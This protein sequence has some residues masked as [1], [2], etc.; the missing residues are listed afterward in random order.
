MITPLR[1]AAAV[2]PSDDNS[3]QA[4]LGALLVS[5]AAYFRVADFLRAEHF[6][7]AI[8]GRIYA[9]I[10]QTI[11]TGNPAV[12]I[13]LG[14]LFDTEEELRPRGGGLQYLLELARNAVTIVNVEFYGRR[15]VE[16][17]QRR[18]LF[19]AAQELVEQTNQ[20]DDLETTARD[21]YA[22]F[23][24][25]AGKAFDGAPDGLPII[26]VG[27]DREPIP[28]RE[29][30]LG[31][32]FCRRFVS[33]LV[34]QGSTG[35]T[36]LRVAQAIAVATGRE[37]TG[38]HV[39]VRCRVLIVS[40]EDNMDELRRRVR[41]AVLHH[42][43]ST[44]ELRGWLFLWTPLGL[45]IADQEDH[46]RKVVPGELN[47]RLRKHIADKK[48]DLVMIDP[49]VKAHQAD[50]ND[51]NAMDQVAIILGQLAVDFNCAIDTPIHERKGGSH[52]IGDGDRGRGASSYR[53]ASRLLYTGTLM[54]EDEREKFGL[55]ENERRS[56]FR[57]D[58]AKV[59]IAPPSLE[60][61][62][63][64]I[65]GV[66]IGNASAVYPAG[67][68]VPTVEPWE[69]PDVWSELSVAIVNA[70]L[71]EIERGPGD[72]RRYSSAGAVGDDRAAWHVVNRHAPELTEKQC[73]RVIA[74]WLGSGM[75]I[76][77]SYQDPAQRRPRQ[78]LFVRKR[79][80]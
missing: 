23:E 24:R 12:P 72:G 42:G 62:W 27:E 73:R 29:W 11:N 9:A 16:M 15:I 45:R 18:S 31:N 75:L 35:K 34:A 53:D 7:R 55:G 54:S 71:D 52:S 47:R 41:A 60:A 74:T 44:E 46:S 22:K 63:F 10:G 58:S 26:D 61:Q 59:N 50:E 57:I 1:G 13:S 37:I 2:P 21:I 5:N 77:Q 51:N 14:A 20:H 67:D 49:L 6:G 36:A 64:R 68:T 43:I 78:G 33:G 79:P 4:L 8:H 39:F 25:D 65:V 40:L 38:E 28:P 3:E 70:I 19:L 48:I 17:Y 32:V 66:P 80:S 69:P 76:N 56:Y 30:L